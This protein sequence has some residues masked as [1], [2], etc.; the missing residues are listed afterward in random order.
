MSDE[1]AVWTGCRILPWHVQQAAFL[2]LLLS[3][4]ALI[5]L[6]IATTRLLQ[7]RRTGLPRFVLICTV[8][9]FMSAT[10]ALGY[11][12]NQRFRIDQQ[13]IDQ[14]LRESLDAR[15]LTTVADSDFRLM[16]TIAVVAM[17]SNGASYLMWCTAARRA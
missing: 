3:I 12:L 11:G 9:A 7:R 17:L 4:A 14:M 2:S 13:R 1:F 8:V 16:L 15:A 6:I 5:T 10:V